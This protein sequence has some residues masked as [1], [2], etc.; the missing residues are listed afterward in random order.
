MSRAAPC[1]ARISHYSPLPFLAWPPSPLLARD[2]ILVLAVLCSPPCVIMLRKSKKQLTGMA[3]DGGKCAWGPRACLGFWLVIA[4]HHNRDGPSDAF[5]D[6]LIERRVMQIRLWA[7]AGGEP[8]TRLTLWVFFFVVVVFFLWKWNLTLP[9]CVCELDGGKRRHP[10]FR[11]NGNK[12]NP[13]VCV[14][15]CLS[16]ASPPSCLL[17]HVIILSFA[18]S[19]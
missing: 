1:R 12:W 5:P 16:V 13:C 11:K 18:C 19:D 8:R 9:Q 3:E 15:V 7:R 10:S 17:I 6:V 14:C 2:F 4:E